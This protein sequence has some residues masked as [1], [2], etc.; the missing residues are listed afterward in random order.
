MKA[1]LIILLLLGIAG[2]SGYFLIKK[3]SENKQS[4]KNTQLQKARKPLPKE[5]TIKLSNNGFEPKEVNIEVGTAVRWVNISSAKQTVNSD[6]YPTNQLNKELNFGVF[7]SGSSVVYIF[8]KTGEYG[9]HN[10]FKPDQKGKIIVT[11]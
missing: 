5:I 1:R 7:S 10:Q 2:F 11:D 6:N 4:A 8:Q 3:N 9:Y